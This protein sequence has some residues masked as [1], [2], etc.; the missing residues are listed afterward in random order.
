M[1]KTRRRDKK[2]KNNKKR[3]STQ[4]KIKNSCAPKNKE[5]VLEF[6]CYTKNDLI[7]MR[8]IWNMRHPDAKIRS[9]KPKKI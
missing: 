5:D 3:K 4:K 2:R 7:K 6:S 9:K 8:N 1:P